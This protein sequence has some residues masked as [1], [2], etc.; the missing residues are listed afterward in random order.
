MDLVYL[1]AGGGAL[2]GAL[3]VVAAAPKVW[4]PVRRLVAVVDAL[5]GRPARYDGDPEARPGLVQR[6]DRIEWH[7]GNGSATPLRAELAELRNDVAQLRAD[8]NQ[9]EV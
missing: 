5:A 6:L 2:G 4:H 9:E 3:L 7:V 1:L 8:R